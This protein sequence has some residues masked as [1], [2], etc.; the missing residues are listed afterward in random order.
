MNETHNRRDFLGRIGISGAAV[1]A[2]GAVGAEPFF[3]NS[4]SKTY[5]AAPVQK[6]N[7]NFAG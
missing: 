5:A 3:G 2:A 4:S 7:H 1:I 6:S